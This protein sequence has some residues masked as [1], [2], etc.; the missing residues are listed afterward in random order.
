MTIQI[1]NGWLQY[2]YQLGTFRGEHNGLIYGNYSNEHETAFSLV[3]AMD[4]ELTEQE[5]ADL[6]SEKVQL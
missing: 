6:Q 2:D 4:V 1:E 5:L 3:D